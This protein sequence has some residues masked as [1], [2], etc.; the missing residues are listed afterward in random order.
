MYSVQSSLVMKPIHS[1]GTSIIKDTYLPELAKGNKIGCFGLTEAH[2]GSDA[3][4]MRT[5]AKKDGDDYIISGSKMW[6]TNALIA[7]IFI[8]WAKYGNSVRGFVLDRDMS[9]ISTHVI[10]NKMSLTSSITGSFSLM[11]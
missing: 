1:Y 7:D 3:S 11:M 6:I 2:S 8:I 4:S 10:N 5:F 9:G